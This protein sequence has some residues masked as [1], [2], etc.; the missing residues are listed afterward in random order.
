MKRT[1]PEMLLGKIG[2]R[3]ADDALQAADALRLFHGRGRC[4][5][6]LEFL[7]VDWFE[8]VALVTLH[9]DGAQ[10]WLVELSEHL[11]SLLG[12]RLSCVL[13]QHR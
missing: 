7:S 11:R 4:F 6:G 8:P 13:A 5:P 10:R 9:T 12:D 2:S 1:V 3:L